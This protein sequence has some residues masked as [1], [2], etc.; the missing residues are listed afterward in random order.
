M[1]TDYIEELRRTNARSLAQ[2]A[3]GQ[4]KFADIIDRSPGQ[5]G[6]II[7]RNP[8]KN[9]GKELAR[10]IERCFRK[11][12]NWLDKEHNHT[13]AAMEEEADALIGELP[14][15]DKLDLISELAQ[16][17]PIKDAAWAAALFSARV[18]REIEGS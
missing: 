3:G 15:Q 11:Q 13:T 6:H 2:Q 10:H 12:K 7:G 9:I 8:S 18:Q 14:H 4:K 1:E 17:L 16:S 5:V